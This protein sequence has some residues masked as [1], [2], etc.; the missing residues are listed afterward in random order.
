MDRF[1]I[2]S[3]GLAKSWQRYDSAHLRDYLVRGVEDPRINVQSILSRH[4][5][6]ERLFGRRFEAVADAELRF[7]IAMNWLMKTVS[8]CARV[9]QLG[10]LLDSLLDGI[11]IANG[12]RIPAYVQSIFDSLPC[13]CNGVIVANYVNE[14]LMWPPMEPVALPLPESVLNTFA[15]I[16]QNLLACEPT[17]RISVIEPACGS[18]NDYR[19]LHA[20]GIAPLIDYCGFDL[21][22][23]NIANARRMFGDAN[24]GCANVLEIGHADKSFDFC[25][26][27]DLFE[28]LSP[29]AFDR[30]VEE[31]V[32]V[33]L[34][35]CCLSFFNAGC[36]PEHIERPI[37]DYHWNTL[38]ISQTDQ[39]LRR[40][41]CETKIIGIDAWL[42][43]QFECGDTHNK[44][45]YTVI[46][47]IKI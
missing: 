33:T 42:R 23:K 47:T 1:K 13:E 36:N 17:E 37:E 18:A 14:V 40:L 22:D 26:V 25:F 45:A 44:Q 11:E 46:A 41:G 34:K 32:R 2:E 4:F 19:F 35:A 9:E 30:A 12:T 27:H 16:W 21:C 31:V 24:F 10:E 8:T 29:A 20:F 39:L 43:Q 38:S 15:T 28:H 5:L 3:E 6:I 7:A